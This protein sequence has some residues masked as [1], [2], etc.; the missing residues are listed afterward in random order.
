MN[1]S[2]PGRGVEVGEPRERP[3]HDE[4]PVAPGEGRDAGEQAE[5][6]GEALPVLGPLVAAV[7]EHCEPG[8]EAVE[9]DRDRD[10]ARVAV[11]PVRKLE[12]REGEQEDGAWPT[13]P[14]LRVRERR[15]PAEPGALRDPGGGVGGRPPRAQRRPD[16]PEERA[17]RRDAQPEVDEDEPW[18]EVVV[19]RRVADSGG[20][21]DEDEEGE[22]DGAEEDPQSAAPR[23]RLEPRDRTTA[24]RLGQEWP[25]PERPEGDEGDHQD[26]GGAPVEEPAGNGQVSNPAQPV[27]ERGCQISRR[28]GRTSSSAIM[29]TR[30]SSSASNTPG[31][32][33]RN[34]ICAGCPGATSARRS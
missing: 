16:V 7:R 10:R 9:D 29:T 19:G 17:E 3:A 20:R 15:L 13:A 27:G 23:D 22:R 6:D 8:H 2:V 33:A 21:E 31:W 11:V 24:A 5:V 32:V 14:P 28:Q 4:P 30:S 18:R 34:L 1:A 12:G 26:D 25:L